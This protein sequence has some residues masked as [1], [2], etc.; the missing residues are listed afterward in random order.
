[1]IYK[2]S[3]NNTNNI[4]NTP[5]YISSLCCLPFTT[6]RHVTWTLNST[7]DIFFHNFFSFICISFLLVFVVSLEIIVWYIFFLLKCEKLYKFSRIFGF[8]WFNEDLCS[9]LSDDPCLES[10]TNLIVN[11]IKDS[12][13]IEGDENRR[14][15]KELQHQND[16]V[17]CTHIFLCGGSDSLV[18]FLLHT[19]FPYPKKLTN[20]KINAKNRAAASVVVV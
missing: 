8:F 10:P 20:R 19:F 16:I 12:R 14:Y 9:Q 1:M 7:S 18:Q 4:H 17:E 5:T 3:Y 2:I 13:S 11:F 6:N 15:L